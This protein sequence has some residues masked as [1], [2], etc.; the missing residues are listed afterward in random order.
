MNKMKTASSALIKNINKSI[1]FDAVKLNEPISRAQISKEKGLNKATVSKM[2]TELIKESLV[3]EKGEGVSSGG[4][5]PV[6]LY[7]NN[8]AGFSIGID[9]GVNYITGLLT[10]LNGF[11]IERTS[12]S[13]QSTETDHVFS[14]LI[15]VIKKLKHNAP[16]SPY[17]I[18]GIGIG[19][20]GRVNREGNILFAPNLNWNNV[21]LTKQIKNVFHIPVKVINEANAGAHGEH[22]LGAGENINNQIYISIGIGIGTGIIINQQLYEG[23][24]GMSGEMGHFSIDVHGEKCTCGNRGCWELYASEYALVSLAS[25]MDI[26]DSED[27]IDMNYLLVEAQK[28]NST[29]L[30]ILNKLGENIGFG[31]INIINTLDP[32]TIIIGNRISKFEEWISEP[33]CRVIHERIP[34]YDN[35]NKADIRFS[36]LKEDAVA[37]GMNLF[38][39]SDFFKEKQLDL[40]NFD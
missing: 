22:K 1:V 40:T 18:I 32:N 6:L 20:P 11:I 4:R 38:A 17:G 29:V 13:T 10:D 27:N 28:G 37:L 39:I 21:Q 19:V 35:Y 15:N 8:L 14:I 34:E 7:F 31:L 25:N 30:E 33:L 2:V 5:K 3:C 9:L 24:F 36:K 12:V 26:T 16:T 23:A